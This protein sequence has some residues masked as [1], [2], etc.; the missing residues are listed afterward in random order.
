MLN[1]FILFLFPVFLPHN[2]R[3]WTSL[4]IVVSSLGRRARGSDA[5]GLTLGSSG[6]GAG[7]PRGRKWSRLRGIAGG[8]VPTPLSPRPYLL[9]SLLSSQVSKDVCN[10]PSQLG[11]W[12]WQSV[13][14]A[15]SALLALLPAAPRNS[16]R[17]SLPYS[18]TPPF[19][20]HCFIRALFGNIS[21][22][23]LLS[24]RVINLRLEHLFCEYR[25]HFNTSF[26]A[27]HWQRFLL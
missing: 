3:S 8:T 12:V 20:S 19:S 2:D 14:M 27:I 18:L 5:P 4:Y 24:V 23:F 11:G 25:K 6:S 17:G 13:V 1:I 26:F 7:D 21:A 9:V 22:M 15:S 10:I 16:N